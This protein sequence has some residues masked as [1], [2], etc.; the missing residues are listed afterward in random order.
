MIKLMSIFAAA[1]SLAAASLAHPASA[2]A[3]PVLDKVLAT[4]TLKVAIGTDWGKLSFLNDKHELDGF[5]VE[6]SKGIAQ[7]LGAQVQFVTPS[8]DVIA[9][10]K[11]EGRWDM[12]IQMTPTN[13]RAEK[14][15]FPVEYF[16][17]PTVAVVHKDSKAT[18]LSD[19]DGKVV[20]VA[21]NTDSAFYVSH[22]LTPDWKGAKPIQYQFTPGEV[23]TYE[24]TNVAFDDL[25]LG[26]GVRLDAVVTDKTIALNAIEAGY[27][28]KLLGG[29]L[30]SSPGAV[31]IE[32]GDKEFS[33]KIAA[34]IKDMNDDGTL[35][36]LSIKWYGVDY[37]VD[38]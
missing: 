31:A 27:P 38:Q 7:R 33:S 5:G 19:L 8:W 32:P 6:V 12:T 28:L 29:N 2:N 1:A 23:K 11:W 10:G 3:G 15:D 24:S 37:T 20:G 18:T 36:K 4:K 21:A 34:A 25:R 9:A 30:Y 14:F 35:S 22:K 17:A 16:W 26:N 13:A